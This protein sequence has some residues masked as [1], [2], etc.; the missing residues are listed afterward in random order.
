MVPRN[1]TTYLILCVA[2]VAVIFSFVN[3]Q[4]FGFPEE[5]GLSKDKQNAQVSYHFL[6]AS[7]VLWFIQGVKSMTIDPSLIHTI[8]EKIT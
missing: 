5:T 7:R 2:I 3:S 1:Q 8:T 6:S 4:D